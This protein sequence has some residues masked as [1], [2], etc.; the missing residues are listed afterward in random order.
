[1][2]V[3]LHL[4]YNMLSLMEILHLKVGGRFYHFL[5]MP[6]LVAEFPFLE[7]VHV[8]K[9]T[10]GWAPDDEVHG[11]E[12]MRAIQ[13]KI[14]RQFCK[15]QPDRMSSAFRMPTGLVKLVE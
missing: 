4:L 2:Q 1:M 13:I 8:R 14:Y 5:C 11:N 12:V 10:A 15:I 6:A 7:M 9:S 3:L